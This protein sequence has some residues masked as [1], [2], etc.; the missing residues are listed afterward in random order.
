MAEKTEKPTQK[1]LDDS[2][3][4]G[5]SFKSKELVSGLVYFIGV[6]Y[7][8]NQVKLD[9]FNQFYQSL[10]LHPTGIS[11]KSYVEVISKLFFDIVLPIIIV[12]FLS[13]AI[14]SLF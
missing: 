6:I 1:K 10:L 9:E 11:L 3:K 8:F 4:K 12:T 5:Q 13:G 2:A 7:L 14:P